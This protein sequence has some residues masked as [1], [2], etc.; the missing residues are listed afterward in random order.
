MFEAYRAPRGFMPFWHFGARMGIGAVG[1]FLSRMRRGGRR[2]VLDAGTGGGANALLAGWLGFR[3]T[4]T[5]VSAA[6]LRALSA[7]AGQAQPGVSITLVRADVCVLPFVDRAFDVV[8][9]SHIIEHLRE[10]EALLRECARVLAIGGVLRVSCPS[11]FHTLR[12]AR[13]LG[14]EVDPDDHVVPGYDATEIA[15]MAPANLFVVSTS[16]QGRFIESNLSDVQ[17]LLARKWGISGNPAV[18]PTGPRPEPPAWLYWAKELVVLPLL[19]AAKAEDILL[20]FAKGS[21]LTVE[22]EKRGD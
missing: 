12:I 3:V 15:A 8:I 14:F 17:A 9:A 7:V 11:R 4:A 1:A 19:C 21:M 16:Y 10:P 20:C 18:G 5:D 13:R 22:F 6:S 2:R